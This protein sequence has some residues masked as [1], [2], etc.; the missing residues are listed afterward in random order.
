M[1][2]MAESDTNIHVLGKLVFSFHKFAAEMHNS[3]RF[4]LQSVQG[5]AANSF[6]CE[7]V[8]KVYFLSFQCSGIIRS[9]LI[10]TGC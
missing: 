10:I 4:S 7:N 2:K 6:P 9:S 8:E 1:S 3:F 5:F